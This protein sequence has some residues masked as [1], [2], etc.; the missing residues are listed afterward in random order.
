MQTRA[1]ACQHLIS[2]FLMLLA[3]AAFLLQGTRALVAQAAASVGLRPEAGETTSGPIHFHGSIGHVLSVGDR[4]VAGHVHLPSD[5]RDHDLDHEIQIWNVSC[6]SAMTPAAPECVVSLEFVGPVERPPNRLF[7]GV[8]PDTLHLP[9]LPP[10][11]LRGGRPRAVRVSACHF[12]GHP[13][14]QFAQAHCGCLLAFSLPPFYRL[15][16]SRSASTLHSRLKGGMVTILSAR[17]SPHRRFRA[18]S[19]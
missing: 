18:S 12:R 8:D 3:V 7:L 15:R 17:S 13:W 10:A 4:N 11:S 6:T 1:Y 2:R 14:F 5:Q 9:P 16:P 19:P